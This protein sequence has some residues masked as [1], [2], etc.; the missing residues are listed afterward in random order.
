MVRI[1]VADGGAVTV[2][3]VPAPSDERTVRRADA[4]EVALRSIAEGTVSVAFEGGMVEARPMSGEETQNLARKTL[5]AF[6]PRG[7]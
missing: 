1:E 6:Y 5:L 3:A 4:F 2:T 7:I